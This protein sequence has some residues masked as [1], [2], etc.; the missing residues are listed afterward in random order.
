MVKLLKDRA[1]PWNGYCLVKDI[2]EGFY[3]YMQKVLLISAAY[4]LSGRIENY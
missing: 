2:S 1:F 4:C 3:Y